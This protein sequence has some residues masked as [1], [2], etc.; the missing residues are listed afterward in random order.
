MD[1]FQKKTLKTS[2]GYTYTYYVSEGDKSL[3]VLFFQHGWPDHAE[4]WK[5]V[6]GPLRSL[7][8]PIIIPD[9]LGYDGTD[10]PTDP[11][12]YKWDGMTKDLIDIVDAEGHQKLVSIG[13]DWGAGCAARMYHYHPDRVAGLILMNVPYVAPSRE[14]FDLD[15]LNSLTETLF[16][17]P[18]QAYW[19]LFTAPDGPALL[20]AHAD[21]VY[22]ILHGQGETMKKF[23]CVPGAFRDYL[24]KGGPE[25][26][27]RPYAD[28]PAAKKAFVDRMTR[29]G[30]EGPQCWYKSMVENHQ[31]DV[32]KNLPAAVD[33]VN[34]P[35]LYIGCKEDFVCRPELMF[36]EKEKG[37][38]PHLEE[39]PM[40]DSAH[41]CTSE[42]P[43]DVVKSMEPWLKKTFAKN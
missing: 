21:R 8:H 24:E 23:F 5:D 36:A 9:M 1:A 42:K 28:D 41:W 37:L 14:K 32:D 43:K 2:R 12:E 26:P 19:Y 11:A 31:H 34:V 40:L 13:H 39:S 29:D 38:L 33:K 30:F 3:P 35:T 20:K 16:G 17:A 7:N 6:A 4:M 27:L 22:H 25:I 18:L 10:K 15:A